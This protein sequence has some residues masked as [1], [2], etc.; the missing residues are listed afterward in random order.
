M[1][2]MS[3]TFF[4]VNFS[5]YGCP[6]WKKHSLNVNFSMYGCPRW[7][8]NTLLHFSLDKY[9]FHSLALPKKQVCNVYAV[10][11]SLPAAVLRDINLV[12][13]CWTCADIPSQTAWWQRRISVVSCIP[14]R[15]LYIT[16]CLL[17]YLFICCMPTRH[18]FTHVHV[19]WSE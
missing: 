12:K 11:E 10:S 17:I 7:R 14:R 16:H 4:N 3:R 2:D 18:K 9:R 8:K 1:L 19:P 6:R 15:K 5:I 13:S